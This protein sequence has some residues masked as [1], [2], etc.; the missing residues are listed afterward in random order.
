MKEHVLCS[1]DTC[2]IIYVKYV[3]LERKQECGVVPTR[4]LQTARDG[5]VSRHVSGRVSLLESKVKQRLVLIFKVPVSLFNEQLFVPSILNPNK[6]LADIQHT[7]FTGFIP[8]KN[9]R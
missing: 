4:L 6:I 2:L 5:N 3:S 9:D 1:N 8:I 7:G